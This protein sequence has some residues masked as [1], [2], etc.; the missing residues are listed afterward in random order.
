MDVQR[1][2][3]ALRQYAIDNNQQIGR[4]VYHNSQ[5]AALGYWDDRSLQMM[6]FHQYDSTTG[7]HSETY[8]LRQHIGPAI[9]AGWYG[10]WFIYTKKMPC[11]PGQRKGIRFSGGHDCM[12]NLIG[13]TTWIPETKDTKP[14]IWVGFEQPYAGW[15]G[16]RVRGQGATYQNMERSWNELLAAR[17][18]RASSQHKTKFWDMRDSRWV[19]MYGMDIEINPVTMVPQAD[20][21]IAPEYVINPANYAC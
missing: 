7:E 6:D 1:T 19:A 3:E 18:A 21:T 16:Q 12:G 14:D 10:K 17:C 9:T 13:T 11:G 5:I 2:F 8:F 20:G 15:P 4:Y